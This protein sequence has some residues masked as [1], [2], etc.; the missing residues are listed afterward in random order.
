MKRLIIASL[1]IGIALFGL[2]AQASANLLTNSGFDNPSSS[3]WSTWAQGNASPTIGSTD[4]YRSSPKSGKLILSS[5]N[6]GNYATIFQTI[7]SAAVGDTLYGNGFVKGN[8]DANSQAYAQFGFWGGSE[9][10][11]V[12]SPIFSAGTFDWSEIGQWSAV[13]P[14]FVNGTPLS[15]VEYGIVIL[16]K[17]SGATGTAYFDDVSADSQPI[18]E[19][20]SMILLGTGL[21]GLF[22]VTRRKS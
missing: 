12:K 18:P 8:L 5:A 15:K 4:A 10:T 3:P 6:A 1:V 9:L 19:P 21:L 17:N 16:A 13:V 2:Q 20:A 22:G 11:M 14:A 7:S